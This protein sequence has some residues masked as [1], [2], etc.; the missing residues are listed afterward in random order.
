MNRFLIPD[1]CRIVRSYLF[2]S[3]TLPTLKVTISS[4]CS[5]RLYIT[6]KDITILA[7]FQLGSSLDRE[8]FTVLFR[9]AHASPLSLLI[10]TKWPQ[11]PEFWDYSGV[12]IDIEPLSSKE[13]DDLF[14]FVRRRFR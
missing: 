11:K 5:R 6:H 14:A 10:S 4:P 7:R 9:S 3:V 1:L 13:L 12:R 2:D 8:S